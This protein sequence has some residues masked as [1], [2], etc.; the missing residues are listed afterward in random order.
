MSLK[1]FFDEF[2]RIVSDVDE[3]QFLD[4]LVSVQKYRFPG[5]SML[6]SQSSQVTQMIVFASKNL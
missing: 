5:I 6:F 3:L 4:Q 2:E 1:E